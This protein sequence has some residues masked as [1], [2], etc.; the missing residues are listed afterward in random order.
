MLNTRSQVKKRKKFVSDTNQTIRESANKLYNNYKLTGL[1]PQSLIV[2]NPKTGQYHS[3]PFFHL[4]L[5]DP[6]KLVEV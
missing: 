5:G 6:V 4:C 2:F 3:I 1:V